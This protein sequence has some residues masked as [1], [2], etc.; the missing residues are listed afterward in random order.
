MQLPSRDPHVH[1]VLAEPERAQLLERRGALLAHG[2][3]CK[4]HADAVGFFHRPAEDPW[5]RGR[6]LPA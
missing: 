5:K 3:R 1:H 2:E 4:F 6:S